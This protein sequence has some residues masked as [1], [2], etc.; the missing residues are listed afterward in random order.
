[1]KE[2]IER[3]SGQ[4]R[5]AVRIARESRLTPAAKPFSNVLISGL[6]GSG[7]G[8]TIISELSAHTAGIPV[9]VSKGYFIPAFVGPGTLFIAS[10]YSGNTEETLACVD[11]A[12][13]TGAHVV[14]ITS[15]GKMAEI[16]R[17]KKL[18]LILIPGGNP[19]RACLGYS[20]T[21]LIHVFETHGL[22][23]AGSLA[24]VETSASLLDAEEPAIVAL[25]K[26]IAARL[27]GKTPVIYSTSGN[28]GIA[29]RFRQQINENS[30]MLCWHQVIPEMNHN[31]LVGWPSGTDQIAVVLFRDHDEFERNNYRIEINRAVFAKYTPHILDVYSKGANAIEKAIYL[32]HLG[33]WVSWFL[34][35]KNGVDATEV[36]VIDF[37]KS[38]L[39]KK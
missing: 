34:A 36:K 20:L 25:A 2:L 7:I 31:E 5:D 37:L 21:Q 9:T 26:D 16:A 3:F 17:E 13:A 35:E 11:Q 10:S 27:F 33:D 38:E 19:P 12:L 22:L 30:K 28:E 24:R 6:G 14:C 23:P 18:D 15:G 4:L 32:V 8:G 39:A 1:M 29:I